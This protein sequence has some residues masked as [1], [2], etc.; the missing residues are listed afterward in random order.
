MYRSA[1]TFVCFSSSSSRLIPGIPI[2]E[3]RIDQKTY[4]IPSFPFCNFRI[5]RLEQFTSPSKL[6]FNLNLNLDSQS[7]LSSILSIF[8]HF[9]HITSSFCTWLAVGFLCPAL[10]WSPL[11]SPLLCSFPQMF[12]WA[13]CLSFLSWKQQAFS[14][15]NFCSVL[16]FDVPDF[17]VE[18]PVQDLIHRITES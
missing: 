5:T 9:R 7:S 16:L 15:N 17:L 14:Y 11:C 13:V 18:I 3:G 1:Q 8:T 4:C 2:L 12:T 6:K 10:S